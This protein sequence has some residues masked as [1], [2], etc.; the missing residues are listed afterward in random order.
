MRR[1]WLML[2]NS[3]WILYGSPKQNIFLYPQTVFSN[4]LEFWRMDKVHTPS[5]SERKIVSIKIFFSI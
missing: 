1:N 2:K 4:Y 3:N 5:A